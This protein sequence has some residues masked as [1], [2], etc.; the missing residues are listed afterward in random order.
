[1][2][3]PTTIRRVTAADV[4]MSLGLSRATV[5]FVLN[6]TPGQTISAETRQRVLAEAARLGYRPHRAARALAS[7]QSRIILLVLPDWPVEYSLGTHLE[8]VS[9]ALDEAGYSLV[10]WTPRPGGRARPL[11]ETLQPDAVMGLMPLSPE[12]SQEIRR[13]GARAITSALL[14]DV[15]EPLE[16]NR[17]PELQIE[18]LAARGRRQLAFATSMDPRLRALSDERLKLAEAVAARLGVTLTH[19]ALDEHNAR[20]VVAGWLRDGVDGIAAYNDDIAAWIAGAALRLG[21]EIPRQLA[22][23]GH[24]DAPVARMMVPALSSINIDTAGLGRYFAALAL[25]AVT[26]AP[27]PA[28]GAETRV[29]VV[30]RESS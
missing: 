19:A 25:H 14:A 6:D 9:H 5:G 17:G 28:L 7:G 26:G 23:I 2:S 16:F 3:E 22:I 10:T 4:A 24:D 20:N 11:W 27:A 1:M 29:M 13:A 30:Q 8:E 18:H 15:L 21:A 12:Q